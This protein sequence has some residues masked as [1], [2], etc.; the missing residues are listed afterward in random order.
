MT[1][2]LA[3]LVA[4]LKELEQTCMAMANAEDSET[5][6][7]AWLERAELCDHLLAALSGP[8]IREKAE[9][10]LSRTG[11]QNLGRLSP[12]DL[13]DFV[14]AA[15]AAAPVPPATGQTDE[16]NQADQGADPQARETLSLLAPEVQ[17]A[18]RRDH[19][20]PAVHREGSLA[21]RTVAGPPATEGETRHR[22][23]CVRVIGGMVTFNGD[24]CRGCEAERAAL[25]AP[26]PTL[27]AD[28][29]LV[30]QRTSDF[31]EGYR[32]GYAHGENGEA[33]DCE[34]SWARSRA[35][36]ELVAPAVPTLPEQALTVHYSG[37]ASEPFW[38]VIN[39][40][41]DDALY[42]LGCALQELEHET[43]KAVQS[44]APE[45]T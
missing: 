17:A 38:A 5:Q 23:D 33:E 11:S 26:V 34:D 45:G 44:L 22:K 36:A 4:R 16:A 31:S 37:A 43:L 2:P 19:S 42:A 15:L 24:Q 27:P 40:T 10:Y 7:I 12:D 28:I 8:A 29:G 3:V 32:A 20:Q 13:V 6:R 30:R 14:L 9:A 39:A 35:S 18:T 21:D 1:D 25:S 41:G